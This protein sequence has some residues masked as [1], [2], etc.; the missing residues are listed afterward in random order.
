MRY[1]VETMLE[2][3]SGG[4]SI[5][6]VLEQFPELEREDLL[7]CIEFARRAMVARGFHLSLT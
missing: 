2:Y 3:L 7:A 4:D 6:T 1:P 5:E